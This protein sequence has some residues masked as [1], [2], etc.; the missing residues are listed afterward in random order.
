MRFSTGSPI[1]WTFH[2][3]HHWPKGDD[4]DD[5]Y[6]D[7]DDDDADI[8]DDDIDDEGT[9]AGSHLHRGS[10]ASLLQGIPERFSSEDFHLKVF[11]KKF[12]FSSISSWLDTVKK[13]SG[14]PFCLTLA[15]CVCLKIGTP[16]A[17]AMF[18]LT[19]LPSPLW[20]TG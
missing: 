8:D 19:I 17:P 16:P 10:W 4:D 5:D 12:S 7:D 3:T 13:K 14:R 15:Q 2:S 20:R 6:D 9:W 1:S 18:S 11:I